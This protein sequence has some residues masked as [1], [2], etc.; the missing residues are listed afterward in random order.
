MEKTTYIFDADTREE[1]VQI[2]QEQHGLTQEQAEAIAPPIPA[3]DVEEWDGMALI[4]AGLLTLTALDR[5]QIHNAI[6]ALYDTADR[7]DLA[8]V[9]GL[10]ELV[11]DAQIE[12]DDPTPE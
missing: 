8:I 10:H 9:D 2:W 3:D 11:I 1:A 6:H 7:E 12:S 4:K 5:Q